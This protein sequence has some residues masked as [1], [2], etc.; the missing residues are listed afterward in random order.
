LRRGELYANRRIAQTDAPT[1]FEIQKRTNVPLGR[2]RIIV[3]MGLA[4]RATFWIAKPINPWHNAGIGLN[5]RR[6]KK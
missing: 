4:H 3:E 1:N 5:A 2:T 6:N